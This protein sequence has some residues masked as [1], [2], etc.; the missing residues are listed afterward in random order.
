MYDKIVKRLT[1]DRHG[2]LIDSNPFV[3]CDAIAERHVPGDHST[4]AL[5]PLMDVFDA[6]ARLV[7]LMLRDRELEVEHEPPVGRRRVV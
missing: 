4:D 1:H 5:E 2:V 7:A 3:L 6:V